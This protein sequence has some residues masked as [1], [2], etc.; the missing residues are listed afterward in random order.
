MN[1]KHRVQ[2]FWKYFETVRKELESHL[3][4]QD[5]HEISHIK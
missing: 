2:N 5:T 1:L 3:Q 4:Q